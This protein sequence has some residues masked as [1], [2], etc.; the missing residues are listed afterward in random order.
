MRTDSI[1]P[2]NALRALVRYQTHGGYVW[3]AVMSDG[4]LMCAIGEL[5]DGQPTRAKLQV[6]DWFTPWTDYRGDAISSDDLLTYCQQFY[7]GG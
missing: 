7:F 5:S 2:V 4:A 1:S 3:A 6:Q